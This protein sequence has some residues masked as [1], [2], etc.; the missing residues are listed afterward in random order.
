MLSVFFYACLC[1]KRDN[2]AVYGK[3]IK[4]ILF[5]LRNVPFFSM[6]GEGLAEEAQFRFENGQNGKGLQ[7]FQLREL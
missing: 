2:H 6:A 5:L 7:S 3:I 4:N 1:G